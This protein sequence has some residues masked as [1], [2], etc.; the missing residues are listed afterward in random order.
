MRTSLLLAVG[1]LALIRAAAATPT[2]DVT[3]CGQTVPDA[4][5]GLLTVDLDCGG[6][7]AGVILGRRSTLQM[8]GHVIANTTIGVQCGATRCTV[9]GPG[10]IYD[11]TQVAVGTPGVAS[12]FKIVVSSLDVHDCAA[13][14]VDGQASRITATDVT[15]V[16][17]S[18]YGLYAESY[19]FGRAGMRLLRVTSSDNGQVGIQATGGIRATE[20]TAERN[21]NAGIAG[22]TVV[23]RNV[24]AKDNGGGGIE[25]KGA[26]LADSTITG[27]DG[28]GAGFDLL[29]FIRP[30]LT[31][32]TCGLSGSSV[33]PMTH[34]GVCSSD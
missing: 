20:V 18:G 6:S 1:M 15:V 30:R 19:P 4:T 5:I 7:S 31:N 28:A 24:V 34:W 29:T 22:L 32:T 10:E 14:I 17:M 13:G 33:P 27:N 21:G 11:A 9:V 16:R 12:K 25:S 8:N 23:G 2:V 3:A 26:R